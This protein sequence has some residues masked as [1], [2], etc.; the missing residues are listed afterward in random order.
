MEAL[1]LVWPRQDARTPRG[2]QRPSLTARDPQPRWTSLRQALITV[3]AL[4]CSPRRPNGK[5]VGR[6]VCD[7][8]W[9]R[10]VDPRRVPY[11]ACSPEAPQ[12]AH[13][14][15]RQALLTYDE[16]AVKRPRPGDGVNGTPNSCG[17]RPKPST[18]SGASRPPNPEQAVRLA[19]DAVRSFRQMPST[20]ESGR[21]LHVSLHVRFRR[22]GE[23]CGRSSR[24]RRKSPQKFA[25]SAK[26]GPSTRVLTSRAPSPTVRTGHRDRFRRALLG[27]S[28]PF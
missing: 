7:A 3:H 28:D 13:T 9:P 20:L 14:R 10:P 18:D 11:P 22:F 16:V 19:R 8:A 15:L 23:I 25:K 4:A 17:F 2:Y 27:E 5:A 26:T 24:N 12:P 1:S 6:G 21:C